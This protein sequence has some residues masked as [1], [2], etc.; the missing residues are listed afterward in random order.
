MQADVGSPE[1]DPWYQAPAEDSAGL[2]HDFSDSATLVGADE[3]TL[4]GQGAYDPFLGTSH[5]GILASP[6]TWAATLA[7]LSADK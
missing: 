4:T 7:F 2:P 6:T 5:L 1:P 3:L